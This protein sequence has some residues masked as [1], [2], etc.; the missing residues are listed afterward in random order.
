MTEREPFSVEGT[1]GEPEMRKLKEERQEHAE[2]ERKKIIN[3]WHCLDVDTKF[4]IIYLPV[5]IV[6]TILGIIL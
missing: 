3:R 2:R 4:Y 6:A 1:F 5:F